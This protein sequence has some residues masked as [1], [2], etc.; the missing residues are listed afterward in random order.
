[1]FIRI[2]QFWSLFNKKINRSQLKDQK[3]PFISKSWFILTFL[4]IINLFWSLL[5]R[6]RSISISFHLFRSILI[7]PLISD[8][9]NW[10]LHNELKSGFKS[11][12]IQSGYKSIIGSGLIRSP[13]LNNVQPNGVVVRLKWVDQNSF[14][15]RLHDL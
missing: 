1:M 12:R 11:N 5:N 6:F 14:L 2:Y 7:F 8:R 9:K 13:M 15:C 4:I 3:S 10:F